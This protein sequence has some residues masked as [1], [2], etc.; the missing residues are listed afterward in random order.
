MWIVLE[1]ISNVDE[2]CPFL[3]SIFPIP[4][5]ELEMGRINMQLIFVINNFLLHYLSKKAMGKLFR[6]FNKTGS[7]MV[8]KIK[9]EIMQR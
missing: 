7:V 5:H 4:C 3:F 1:N 8:I 6:K 2:G 9:Y